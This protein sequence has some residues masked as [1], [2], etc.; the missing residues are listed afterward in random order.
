[1]VDHPALGIVSFPF[2]YS[3]SLWVWGANT[4]GELGNHGSVD[5]N[6]P[7]L[8]D[9]FFPAGSSRVSPLV[10]GMMA[11]LIAWRWPGTG[12]CLPGAM[13]RL[14]RSVTAL[15]AQTYLGQSRFVRQGK[16]PHVRS[17]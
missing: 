17:S 8:N 5:I 1:V 7:I 3:T 10:T 16:L 4:E 2:P 13:T 14:A 9:V 12:I 6:H 15:T 11:D